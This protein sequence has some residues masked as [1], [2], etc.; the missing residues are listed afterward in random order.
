MRAGGIRP[1]HVKVSYAQAGN[2]RLERDLNCALRAGRERFP[3]VMLLG[4]VDPGSDDLLH[5]DVRFGGIA[6]RYRL[7]R[8]VRINRCL[9]EIDAGRRN[10]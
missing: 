6:Q 2:C 3:A 5:G 8:A 7:G 4:E 1:H 9:A 10:L